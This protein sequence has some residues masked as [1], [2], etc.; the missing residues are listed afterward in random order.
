MDQTKKYDIVVIGSGAG[1]EILQYAVNHGYNAAL[2]DKGPA[3]GTCLNVGC[4]PTKMMTSVADRIQEIRESNK[5]G[6][7]SE[8]KNIN[9]EKIMKDTKNAVQPSHEQIKQ[10]LRTSQGF[11]FYEG[12][13]SFIDEKTLEVNTSE[14]TKEVQGKKIFIASGARPNIPEIPGL[15]QANYLTNENILDLKEIPESMTIIGGGYI[16]VEFA[17]FFEAIGTKVNMIQRSER[18]VKG[19]DKEVSKLL[20][21]KLSKRMDI[22]TNTSIKEILSDNERDK[23]IVKI[24]YKDSGETKEKDQAK[25]L[26]SEK[27]FVAT[28]R[29]S[30]ADILNTENAGLEL[31]EKGFIKVDEYLQTNKDHIW[32]FGDAIGKSM[33]THS[34]RK[35]ASLAWHNAMH[36]ELNQH[37]HSHNEHNHEHSKEHQ[38]KIPV[39]HDKTPKAIFSYPQVASIGMTQEQAVK[40][41]GRRGVLVGKAHYNETAKGEALRED[42]GFAK[43]ILKKQDSSII[44]FHIIG[45][46]APILIQ[47][48][49]LAMEHGGNPNVLLGS[50]HI[51]PA[52][53]ELIPRTFANLQM[54]QENFKE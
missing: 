11:D 31:D 2:I 1:A 5:F 48:V 41:Y 10:S 20:Y 14:G 43:L 52:L 25:E 27:I 53:S 35:E 17:H 24:S 33:F 49:I 29:K 21:D 9:F 16:A 23:N 38:Q 22:Y 4:I 8:I 45:P 44:G 51:H 3:G 13:A 18:L 36:K 15:N 26:E 42:K 37:E 30:N 12:E 34:S 28:G 40:S 46:Y 7:D 19:E 39:Y 47:E 6:I 50:T 54:P 32:A